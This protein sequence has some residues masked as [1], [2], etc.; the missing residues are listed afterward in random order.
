M[1][2]FSCFSRLVYLFGSRFLKYSWKSSSSWPSVLK[3]SLH[4]IHS[5]SMFIFYSRRFIFKFYWSIS[6]SSCLCLHLCCYSCLAVF[7]SCF[8]NFSI[9]CDSYLLCYVSYPIFLSISLFMSSNVLFSFSYFSVSSID[10]LARDLNYS[11]CMY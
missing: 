11:T 2:L 6:F 1:Y 9:C 3:D 10:F 5:C 7:F 8:V 4:I